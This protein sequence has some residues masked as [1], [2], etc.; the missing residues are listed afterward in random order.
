MKVVEI[1]N[2]YFKYRNSERYILKNVN[3]SIEEGETVLIAGESGSG[4]STL[5]SCI[6]G[7][8]PDLYQGEL[9]GD[10]LIS[11]KRLNEMTIA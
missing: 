5:C 1:K 6:C 11:G 10:V 7:L 3:L 2:L 4:K 9:N 8:I